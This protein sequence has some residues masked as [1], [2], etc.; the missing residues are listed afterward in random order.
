[1]KIG[2]A[3]LAIVG[4]VRPP[5][6]LR[7]P[8]PTECAVLAARAGPTRQLV[9]LVGDANL[10]CS[11]CQGA[12]VLAM[13]RRH[14]LTARTAVFAL[15]AAAEAWTRKQPGAL[16]IRWDP[17]PAGP[18]PRGGR[19]P[20]WYRSAKDL[21]SAQKLPVAA[22]ALRC[23]LDVLISDTDVAFLGD[24]FA[25]IPDE[26]DVDVAAMTDGLDGRAIFGHA[27]PVVG[28]AGAIA[29]GPPP[30]ER[31]KAPRVRY[32]PWFHQRVLFNAGFYF[33]R[34]SAGGGGAHGD[35]RNRT[36][37]HFERAFSE[38]FAA[39]DVWDQ[40]AFNH[41]FT[42]RGAAGPSG[43]RARVLNPYVF[44]TD[45]F[46]S[47]WMERRVAFCPVVLHAN[48]VQRVTAGVGKAH[49]KAQKLREVQAACATRPLPPH[50]P[51][52]QLDAHWNAFWCAEGERW[53]DREAGVEHCP[54]T[55]APNGHG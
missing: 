49:F 36:A 14:N 24:P 30:R 8:S 35:A 17:L 44:A 3:L 54:P 25:Y 34:A 43:L 48:Y 15:D 40:D 46:F 32:E 16:A 50:V 20:P 12:L 42:P 21:N 1:M 47:V 39:D 22:F 55:A 29:L 38:V 51:L 23:G 5:A 19:N 2:W 28:R 27:Q 18:V 6:T 52:D 9:A 4:A 31:G 45:L 11:D 26:P 13:L 7:Q 33:A 37:R 53:A 41:L 10:F